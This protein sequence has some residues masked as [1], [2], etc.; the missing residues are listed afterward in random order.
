MARKG[1]RC[2]ADALHGTL[3]R[4]KKGLQDME[5]KAEVMHQC[6]S[7]EFG[8]SQTAALAQGD[9][10]SYR[11]FLGIMKGWACGKCCII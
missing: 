2:Q 7:T 6:N 9:G 3:F 8:R 11:V 10:F 4:V 5:E 1:R